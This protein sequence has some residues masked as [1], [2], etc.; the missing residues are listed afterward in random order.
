MADRRLPPL[1]ALRAF[2][3]AAR[4]LS[5][6]RAGQELH[7]TQAAISH[8]VKALERWLGL[9]LFRR[10]GRA[11]VLT[12]NGQNY[13]AE[14]REGLDRLAAATDRLT[15]R[16][17][18]G[19]LTVATLASFAAAW[20]MPRLG[21][22]RALHPDIDVRVAASDEV[23]DFARDDVDLAIRY[24]NGHWPG[25]EVLPLMTED[26][27]P[28]CSPALLIGAHPLRRPEDLRHHTLLH[29]DMRE[30]WRLW[31][32]A[33]GVDG[34]DP[35]RG[36]GYNLSTLVIDAAADGQGVAL[37]RSALL[38]DHLSTGRLVRPFELALPAEF[39]YYLVHP[40]RAIE[41]PKVRAFRDWAL[42]EAAAGA[43]GA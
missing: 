34:V 27:F 38:R 6:T 23:V 1:N 28:V 13:L 18:A 17:D 26:V 20:L 43:G 36:P 15:R 2:E 41:H 39:A 21:R 30:T 37:A 31:L 7:V 8:Q 22:F 29:D 3:A 32:L 19:V 12:E 10:R 4:L 9:A 16:Q 24:G 40:P 14:V 25:L 42:V 11:V 5:F 35:H 33:A